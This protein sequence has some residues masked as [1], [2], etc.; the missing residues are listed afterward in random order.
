M[1]YLADRGRRFPGCVLSTRIGS[2]IQFQVAFFLHLASDFAREDYHASAIRGV[3]RHTTRRY[4]GLRGLIAAICRIVSNVSCQG[5]DSCIHLGRVL[6]SALTDGSFRFH[7]SI[8]FEEDNGLI[9]YSRQGVIARRVFVRYH[10]VKANYA[11]RGRQVRSVRSRGLVAG[12]LEAEEGTFFVR[13]F[14]RVFRVGSNA[15]GRNFVTINGARRVR[16]RPTFLLRFF[17]LTVGLFGRTNARYS[18]AASGRI[19]CLV[20]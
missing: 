10:G 8:M 14:S 9:Y 1:A 17:L 20:F 6:R 2:Q 19:R 11:V 15:H 12:D 4:F 5:A 18:H 13:F 7:V 3:V 16:F